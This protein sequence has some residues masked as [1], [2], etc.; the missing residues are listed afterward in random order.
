MLEDACVLTIAGRGRGGYRDAIRHLANRWAAPFETVRYGPHAMNQGEIRGG[1]RDG[2]VIL[3][4]GGVW[5][6]PYGRDSME[7]LAVDL[8]RRG[9]GSWNIGYRRTGE[10]GGWPGSA[11]DV[12]TALDHASRFGPVAVIGHSAGGFLSMWATARTQT[13]PSQVVAL[14]PIVDLEMASAGGEIAPDAATL[15][16]AGAPARVMPRGVP[17][18]VIHGNRDAIVPVEHSLSITEEGAVIQIVDAGH[19]DL[20]DPAKPHWQSVV[21]QLA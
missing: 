20:L 17:T 21:D 19:Y 10:G 18:L 11:H 5:R 12:L 6:Q 14:A 16:A 15:L 7:S 2:L 3:V 9:I 4:H 1:H 8:H 13:P